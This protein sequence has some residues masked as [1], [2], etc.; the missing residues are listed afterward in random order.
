MA[1]QASTIKVDGTI[2]DLTFYKSGGTFFVKQK[3]AVSGNRIKNDPRFVRT[4]E[5]MNEFGHAGQTGKALRD[6]FRLLLDRA[7]DSRVTSRLV[8]RLMDVLKTDSTNVRG[9]RKVFNGNLSLLRGFEF[10]DQG[11]FSGTL[12]APITYWYR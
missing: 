3:R 8:A 9:E 1:R 10:N 7:S 12:F 6:G 2:G 4:R 11:Q 5:N